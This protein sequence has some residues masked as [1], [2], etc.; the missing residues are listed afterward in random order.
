MKRRSLIQTAILIAFLAASGLL[1][2]RADTSYLLIQGPFGSG[3][4]TQTYKWQVNYTPGELSTGFDLLNAVFGTPVLT[5]SYTDAYSD[6]YPEYT[7]SKDGNSVQYYYYTS[8]SFSGYSPISFTLGGTYVL[9]DPTYDPGWGYYV[10]GG[11]G[12]YSGTSYQNNGSWTF[13][14]DGASARALANGSYDGWVFGAAFPDPNATIDDSNSDADPV[15]SEFTTTDS[16]AFYQIV[17]IPEPGAPLL[18]L[19]AAGLLAASS[20]LRKR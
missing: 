17:D 13:S 2:A 20:R 1:A 6:N 19:A 9:Q 3:S 10:A 8:S 18:L 16:S 4:T 7:S 5:G 12:T 11:T 14:S 15:Q